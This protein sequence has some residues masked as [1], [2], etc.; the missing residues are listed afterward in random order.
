RHSIDV[1]TACGRF[2]G[3][4][5]RCR[6]T[7][8]ASLRGKMS[9]SAR[10]GR[11]SDRWRAALIVVFVVPALLC[12]SA[13]KLARASFYKAQPTLCDCVDDVTVASV[14]CALPEETTKEFSSTKARPHA[15]GKVFCPVTSHSRATLARSQQPIS[16]A[17][18]ALCL[19]RLL[20]RDAGSSDDP[21]DSH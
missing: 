14:L 8:G 3:E 16:F 9:R 10:G 12:A 4:E 17:D 21:D 11:G 13:V 19:K 18:P 1:R 2:R 20:A 15:H 6:G 7:A 5:S